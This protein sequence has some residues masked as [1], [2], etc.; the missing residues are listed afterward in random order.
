MPSRTRGGGAALYGSIA[1]PGRATTDYSNEYFRSGASVGGLSG[2]AGTTVT[3]SN[4]LLMINQRADRTYAGNINGAGGLRKVGTST[5]TLSGNNTYGSN[6]WIQA[7]TLK[8]GSA[9]AYPN[10]T[11]DLRLDYGNLDLNGYSIVAQDVYG[12]E[13]KV[14]NTSV[15]AATITLAGNNGINV[16]GGGAWDGAGTVGFIKTTTNVFIQSGVS[17]FSGTVA[18]NPWTA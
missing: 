6:T 15:T 9:T 12:R 16:W 18:V 13:G 4:G 7:G 10:N 3:V 11:A 1:V 2:D 5:L 17:R 14:T 8:L